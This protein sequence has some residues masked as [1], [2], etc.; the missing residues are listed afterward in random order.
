MCTA[1]LVGED[2]ADSAAT[3]AVQKALHHIGINPMFQAISQ[4]QGD[5]LFLTVYHLLGTHLKFCLD[6]YSGISWMLASWCLQLSGKEND[7]C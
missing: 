5:H 2:V 4:L 7:G 3:P 6:K 1:V